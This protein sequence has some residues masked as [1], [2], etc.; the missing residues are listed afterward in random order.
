MPSQRSILIWLGLGLVIGLPIFVAAQSPLL[1]WR[2]PIYIAAGF[3][4]IISM[5]LMLIQP[6]LAGGYLPGLPPR[7][8]RRVHA[9]TGAALVCAV[10]LHVG[11]LWVTSPPDVIDA[12]AFRAPAA[13]SYLGVIAMWAVIGAA[14]LAALRRKVAPKRWRLGHSICVTVAVLT[15]VGHAWLIDGTMGFMTKAMICA[16]AVAATVKVLSDLRV[17]R[18]LPNAR[19]HR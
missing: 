19:K 11:G 16:L 1:E 7:T 10:L 15:G 2:A 5:A 17:W 12:L 8:G 13:F 18:L 6:L 3:A 9:V 14:C 4:G